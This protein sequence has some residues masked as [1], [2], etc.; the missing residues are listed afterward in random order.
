LGW[1]RDLGLL[2]KNIK[3]GLAKEND[4]LLPPIMREERGDQR[5]PSIPRRKSVEFKVGGVQKTSKTH[6]V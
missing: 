5:E 1:G 6:C 4:D 3:K 2:S